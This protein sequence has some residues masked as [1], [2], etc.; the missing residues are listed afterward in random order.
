M[1]TTA[2]KRAA[3]RA[4]HEQGCFVLPNPWDRGT[5]RYLEHRGF[6]A[7]ATTSSGAA[8]SRGR[9]DGSATR[10][11]ALDHLADIVGATDLPVNADF[12]DGY[13]ATADE[14]AASVALAVTTGV[15][16]LSIEDGAGGTSYELGVAVERLSAA[17]EAIDASGHDVLLVGR[18]DG[19]FNGR[20]DLDDILT[21]LRA[22]SRAGA[23]CLY[24]P[25]IT[26]PDQ[27]AAVVAAVAPRPVNLL[28]GGQSELTLARVADLGVRRVSVGGALARTAWGGVRTA[29]D[30]LA[31]GYFDGFAGAA[32]GDELNG[33][34]G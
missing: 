2:E 23:D 31:E 13:G 8:W 4:L 9:P 28:I 16:G 22:F 27:V 19:F 6:A 14:V 3:F 26:A 1:T 11:E 17:R 21:R 15:A 10:D 32:Q 29:V 30:R 18:A 5:A 7:L 20:P 33:L 25:G 12:E 24:A 34:F